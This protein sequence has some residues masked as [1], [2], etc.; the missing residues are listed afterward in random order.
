MLAGMLLALLMSSPS[1]GR[2]AYAEAYRRA[3]RDGVP[4]IVHVGAPWCPACVKM[5][6]EQIEKFD[7]DLCAVVILN[8]DDSPEFARQF[9]RGNSIPQTVIYAGD[10]LSFSERIVGYKPLKISRSGD[11]IVIEHASDRLAR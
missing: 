2:E 9:M 6:R 5:K 11:C 7:P 8:Y 4:L 1:S 10:D 3:E